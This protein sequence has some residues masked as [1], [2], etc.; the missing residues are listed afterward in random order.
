MPVMV[1]ANAG[2]PHVEDGKTVFS[3]DPDSYA[4]SVAG[5]VEA[6]VRMWA[7]AVERTPPILRIWR[8]SYVENNLSGLLLNLSAA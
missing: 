6:G 7:A 1:Q 5:M 2:L 4:K 8:I 3:V